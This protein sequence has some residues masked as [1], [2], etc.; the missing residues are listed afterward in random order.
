MEATIMI[1]CLD[2][3]QIVPSLVSLD[4]SN[5]LAA[6]FFAATTDG[7]PL[8][9]LESIEAPPGCEVLSRVDRVGGVC[10]L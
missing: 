6:S 7:S 10:G 2:H 4:C 9:E 1:E 3:I 8:E 5:G